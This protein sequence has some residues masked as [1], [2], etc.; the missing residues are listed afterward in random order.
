MNRLMDFVSNNAL[1]STLAGA[2]IVGGIAWMMKAH[3]DRRDGAV[4]YNS[5]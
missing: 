2:A 1:G 5:S 3:R 4:I